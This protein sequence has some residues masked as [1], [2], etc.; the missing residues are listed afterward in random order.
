MQSSVLS[1]KLFTLY[2]DSLFTKLKQYDC[3]CHINNTYMG[4]LS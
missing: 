1:V 2:I 3:G 4:A